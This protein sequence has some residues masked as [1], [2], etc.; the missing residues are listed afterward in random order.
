MGKCAKCG[1]FL[2]PD[3]MI[4]NDEGT[5]QICAFCKTGK[6]TLTVSV[7]GSK[8][9]R[10]VTKQECVNKY[11]EFVDRF[12]STDSFRKKVLKETVKTK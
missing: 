9:S 10:T 12:V 6:N 1:S 5:A 3:Y 4:V 7:E 2:G 11:K 8:E